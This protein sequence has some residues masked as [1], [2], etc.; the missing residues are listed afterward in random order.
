MKRI[1]ILILFVSM[2][3]SFFLVSGSI[4][5]AEDGVT[6][7]EILIGTTTDISGP[8]AFMGQRHTR[9]ALMYFRY[10]N[11]QG[12]IHGRKIKY[13]IEDDAFQ[14]PRTV[15]AAK[16]LITKDKVFCMTMNLGAA[17]IFAILPLIENYDVPML[18]TGTGNEALAI[19]PRKNVFVAD[20]SYRVQG[21]LALK[22]VKDV[23]KENNPKI[24]CIYQEDVTGVQYLNG[25]KQGA[26]KYFGI[27]DFPVLSYKRGAV[28]FSSH[29]AKCKM[30]GAT[31]VF[32]HVNIREPAA[33]LNEA[34]RIQYSPVYFCNGSSGTNKVVELCGDSVNASKGF[35]LVS[36]GGDIWDGMNDGIKLWRKCVLKYDLKKNIYDGLACWGFQ[37]AWVLCEVLKRAGRDLTR[38]NFIKAAETMDNYETGLM[39]PVTWRS[40]KRLGGDYS[41]IWK[42]DAA[43]NKW[44]LISDWF[45]E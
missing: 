38:E 33:I 31:H 14:P 39:V 10:I 17:G 2:F 21:D 28:D 19:P 23:L 20:T 44:V 41:R 25:V 34:Q 9:G 37:S 4:A 27:K 43:K 32:L 3:L 45:K 30:V 35:Y 6:D 5:V 16:K 13:L 18:P 24:A 36:H 7:D 1:K 12:G 11:D 8:L 40:G 29:V 15:Q 42:A 26:A 22:Y